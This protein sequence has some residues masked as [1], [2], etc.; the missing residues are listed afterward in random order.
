MR[1]RSVCWIVVCALGLGWRGLALVVGGRGAD[2]QQAEKAPPAPHE[3]VIA[4]CG[5]PAIRGACPALIPS[6]KI[7]GRYGNTGQVVVVGTL[8]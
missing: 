8:V 4:A 7:A 2:P 6:R 1:C 3:F 5:Q